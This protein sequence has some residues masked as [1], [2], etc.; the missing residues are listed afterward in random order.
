MSISRGQWKH[1]AIPLFR[2]WE[3]HESFLPYMDFWIGNFVFEAEGTLRLRRH[4][5]LQK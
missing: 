3:G 4:F 1:E 2:P 5:F